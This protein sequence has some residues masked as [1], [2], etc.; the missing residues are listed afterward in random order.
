MPS[1]SATFISFQI[2]RR[3][4]RAQFARQMPRYQVKAPPS[5]KE[6]EKGGAPAFA[7]G[8][9]W[10]GLRYLCIL[11]SHPFAQNAKGWGTLIIYVI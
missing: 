3:V 2:M 6:R 7:C 4:S 9:P 11:A 8:E 5:R 10:A 1:K